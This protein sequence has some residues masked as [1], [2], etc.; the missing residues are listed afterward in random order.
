MHTS[1]EPGLNISDA[2]ADKNCTGH[3]QPK[4]ITGLQQHSWTGFTAI[5]IRFLRMWAVVYLLYYTAHFGDFSNHLVVNILN[6]CHRD[7]AF[8]YTGLICADDNPMAG[9]GEFC[10]SL[11]RSR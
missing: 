6:H 8:C 3:L 5:A 7:D 10:N 9:T 1:G 11:A 2:I 4:F